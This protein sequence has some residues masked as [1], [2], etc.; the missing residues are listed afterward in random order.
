[1]TAAC[2]TWADVC[3]I[4]I[5]RKNWLFCW[6]EIGA[7]YVGIFQSLLATCRIQGIDPDVYLVDILQR[8]ETHPAREVEM[9]TPRLWK[10]HF[11][12][13][14]LRSVVD[15]VAGKKQEA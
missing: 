6:T 14:P 8:I 12:G 4:A 7:H 9:L 10:Q 15:S 13:A 1:M 11:A 2:P 3:P 5:G